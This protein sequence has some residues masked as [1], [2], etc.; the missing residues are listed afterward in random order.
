MRIAIDARKLR[1]F[2][3]GTYIRNLL[4]ELSRLDQ[5]TEYVVLCRP[6]DVESGEVLGRNFRMVP[7]TAP[8]YSIAEQ[9]RIPLALSR[10]RV[11]LVHEPH[12]VL[13]PA[14]RCRSVV[15]IHDCIHLMFPQYLPGKLAYVYAKASMWFATRKADRI[16]TVSEASKRDILRFFD[17]PPDKV[18][19]IHNAID[20]RFLGPADTRRMDLVRQR[21]QLDH[22][23]ILYVGNIKPHKNI[24]RLIDAFGRAR[25]GGPAGLKLV[26][27]GDEI[28]KYPALRQAVH[29]HKLDKQVRFLGFQP[30]ETLA[31]FYRLARAFVFPSLYEGFG[32]PP[33]EAM[34]CGTPVVTSNV[35][36]LPEVA[37][38]AALLVDPHDTDAIADGIRRA[39]N[40][41]STRADLIARGLARA[42][43]FSWAQS[44]AK[45]HKIYMEVLGR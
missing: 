14:I 5:Q 41:E 27:I 17:V 37:G 44:V 24:E 21:Y 42:R 30:Q 2:G 18:S 43:E 33:L 6:D 28:S 25:E 26:I 4:I 16:L 9:I 36:S 12:Y 3:I 40:D 35:S 32:L 29:R 11:Q 15:T 8:T 31:A 38:G 20:E 23:F 13:P 22:P 34:A 7:E 10:E 39:V 19:V 1:D 45:I